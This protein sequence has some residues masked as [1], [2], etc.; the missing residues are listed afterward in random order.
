MNENPGSKMSKVFCRAAIA[1]IVVGIASTPA[2]NAKPKS[3]TADG[4]PANVVAHVVLSGGPVTR[5]LLVKKNGKEFLLLGLDSA[6]RVAILDVSEPKQPRAIDT[7][8]G[9]AGTS[10]TELK[11]I[12]DTLTLFGTSDAEVTGASEPKEVRSLSGV[13]AFMKDKG[14]G[15]IYVTNGD[16]LW[17]VKTKQ[18]ADADAPAADNSY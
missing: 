7:A 5:M 10:A 3:K 6:T 8:P 4:N 15:L 17:I 18:K 9:A 13:T 12:A 14:H 1:I 11:L 2:V 16:G